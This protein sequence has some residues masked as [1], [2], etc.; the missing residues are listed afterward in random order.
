MQAQQLYKWA[1]IL[2]IAILT[3]IILVYAKSFL[4]PLA[5]AGLLAMLLLPV[6]KWLQ[7]KR[8]NKVV[9]MLAAILMLVAGFAGIIYLI[10]WQVSDLA[11]DLNDVEGKLSGYLQQ[12]RTFI[13]DKFG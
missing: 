10:P 8:F 7:R 9:A 5:F 4:V 6:T 3:V 2:L 13:A 12:A 1:T 11:S